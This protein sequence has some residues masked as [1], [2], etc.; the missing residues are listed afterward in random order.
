MNF[1]DEWLPRKT[2]I[3]GRKKCKKQEVF[4]LRAKVVIHI[5]SRIHSGVESIFSMFFL[6]LSH[7]SGFYFIVWFSCLLCTNIL[8]SERHMKK[9][10]VFS[11]GL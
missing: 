8:L 9:N 2:I 5:F 10:S 7:I 1:T 11:F 4:L 3:L 6:V